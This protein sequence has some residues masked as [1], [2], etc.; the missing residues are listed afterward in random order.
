[1]DKKTNTKEQKQV[2]NEISKRWNKFRETPSPT[3]INFLKDKKGRILDMGC[4]SGRNFS[5]MPEDAEIYALDFSEEMLK[6]ALKKAKKIKL[7][8]KIIKSESS[9]IPFA[10][11]FFDAIVCFAV[12]HCIPEKENRIKTLEEI[13]RTLKKGSEAL[14]TVWS[15]N[16]PRLKNKPKECFIP[17][18]VKSTKEFRKQEQE[19]KEERYT[20]IYESEELKKDILAAGFKIEKEWE[21]RNVNFIVKK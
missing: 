1:M 2:W 13:Y 8:I 15:R 20:Y 14:I 3:I 16:S 5:A 7:N 12:L 10:D 18:T 11:N 4:G 6:Y 19:I 9:S 21:E 17:W